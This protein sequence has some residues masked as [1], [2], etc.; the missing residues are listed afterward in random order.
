MHLVPEVAGVAAVDHLRAQLA[1]RLVVGVRALPQPLEQDTGERVLAAVQVRER[2]HPLLALDEQPGLEDL[3]LVVVERPDRHV[4][5]SSG[6]LAGADL[7]GREGPVLT[8]IDISVL[9]YRLG[10][11]PERRL[12][13][14]AGET[15]DELGKRFALL[16]LLLIQT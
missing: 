2:V 14:L 4:L 1:G 5:P 7:V 13:R 8:P 11:W 16:P 10:E 15:D 9:G 6:A 3:G 12:D